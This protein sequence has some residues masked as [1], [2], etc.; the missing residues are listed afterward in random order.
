MRKKFKKD[1][2]DMLVYTKQEYLMMSNTELRKRRAGLRI[3]R[4]IV[5][6]FRERK[7]REL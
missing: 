3:K 2:R 1:L 6:K 5:K 4:F 7:L